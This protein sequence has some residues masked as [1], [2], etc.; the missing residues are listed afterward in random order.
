MKR[1][2]SVLVGV[3]GSPTSMQTLDWAAAFAARLGWPLHIVCCYS[4][5]HWV[6]EVPDTQNAVAGNASVQK[7]A[8]DI[9]HRAK[10]R[11]AQFNVPVSTTMATGDPA[12]VLIEMSKDH[13]L[14]VVGAKG[15]RG[16]TERLVGAV[17]SEVPAHSSAPVLVVPHHSRDD[18]AVPREVKRIVIGHDGSAPAYQALDEALA[19]SK[20]WGAELIAVA[21]VP[22]STTAGVAAWLPQELDQEK[23]LENTKASLNGAMDKIEAKNPGTKIRRVVLDGTGA[24]LLVE[25][26]RAADLI[27]VGSRGRGGFRGLLMGST[28]QAVVHHAACPV[29]VVPR[30]AID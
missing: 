19:H 18:V 29:L 4:P 27:V 22:V 8:R 21:A 25:F 16:L 28:S 3:D 2:E 13:G 15:N 1:P 12:G 20:A 30:R 6:G 26:S 14:V 7:S 23:V 9:L 24:D 5:P 10:D 17:S 11:V